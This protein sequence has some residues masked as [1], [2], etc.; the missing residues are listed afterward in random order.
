MNADDIL[1]EMKTLATTHNVE[2][3]DNAV[4]I[5][6][7]RVR[8]SIPLDKCPCSPLDKDRGCISKKCLTEIELFGKCHCQ[9]YK[10][11]V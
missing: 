10:K 1:L 4:N 7:F 9:A 11:G 6:R 5:A 2:L 3:T 8:A